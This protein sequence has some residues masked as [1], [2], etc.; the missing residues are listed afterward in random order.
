[1]GERPVP[2]IRVGAFI[3]LDRRVLLVQ[4]HRAA[5][6]HEPPYW[7]L[8]GG[9]VE[10]GESLAEALAR[11]TREELGLAIVV[12]RPIALVESISPDTTY[13]KKHVVHVVLAASLP[14]DI[15]ADA[16]RPVAQEI[17]AARFFGAHELQEL[18][19]RPPIGP[20]L[21]SYLTELPSGLAYLGRLW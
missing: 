16:L 7:L 11:E 5:E 15:H 14:V 13:Y 19:L 4:Q 6:R 17:T 9:G 10:F 8:P 18:R 21:A 12:D 20:H 1:V 2:T 3:A